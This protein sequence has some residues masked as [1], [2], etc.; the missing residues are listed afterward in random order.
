MTTLTSVASI[1]LASKTLESSSTLALKA[2]VD[3]AL[4]GKEILPQTSVLRLA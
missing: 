3:V 1:A 2:I 4:A